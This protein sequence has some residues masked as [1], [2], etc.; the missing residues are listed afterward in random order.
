MS[1]ELS[2]YQRKLQRT[3]LA[4]FLEKQKKDDENPLKHMEETALQGFIA[5]IKKLATRYGAKINYE[6]KATVLKIVSNLMK[7]PDDIRTVYELLS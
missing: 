3:R 6:Q 2:D 7:S 1:N 5:D 4:E